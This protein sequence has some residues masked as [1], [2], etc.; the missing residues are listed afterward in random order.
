MKTGPQ[1]DNG[2]PTASLHLTYLP[3]PG[4][5]QAWLLLL[6]HHPSILFQ[7]IIFLPNISMYSLI[8][9][10]MEADHH[11]HIRHPLLPNLRISDV[12][13]THTH[14]HTHTLPLALHLPFPAPPCLLH[15]P[16]LAS[17][18]ALSRSFSDPPSFPIFFR[19]KWVTAGRSSYCYHWKC[20]QQKECEL[21][22]AGPLVSWA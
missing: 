7:G 22:E 14:T 9:L 4:P 2:L 13:H 5:A 1:A 6:K 21:E 19:V 3:S 8:H 12:T 10:L 18:R 20:E 16:S 17:Q 15:P 11:T